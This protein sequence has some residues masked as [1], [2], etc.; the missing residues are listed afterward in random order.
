LLAEI[1]STDGER[2]AAKKAPG[3]FFDRLI[4][5]GVS[6]LL[7]RLSHFLAEQKVPSY[8]VGGFVRDMLLK[9]NTADIDIA[10]AA[11]ALEIARRVAIALDG[12]YIPMGA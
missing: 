2:N 10:V 6:L 9:R 3:G 1:K 4:E 11:D 8:I 5:S 7:T 12:K